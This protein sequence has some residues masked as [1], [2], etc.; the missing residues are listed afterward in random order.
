MNDR[1]LDYKDK[2]E[3]ISDFASKQFS[4]KK[5]LDKMDEEWKPIQF[6]CKDWKGTYILDGEAVEIIQ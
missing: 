5:I 4:N 6:T 3:E 2:I 1:V